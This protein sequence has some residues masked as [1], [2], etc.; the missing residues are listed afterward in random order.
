MLG[1]IDGDDSQSS[2]LR[3]KDL[4][5]GP[6]TRVGAVANGSWFVSFIPCYRTAGGLLQEI[7]A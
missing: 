5:P 2:D 3:C 1:V 4:P 6:P 7:F